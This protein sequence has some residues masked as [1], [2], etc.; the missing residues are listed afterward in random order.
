MKGKIFLT[1]FAL[2]FFGVGVWML[3]A[4]GSAVYDVTRMNDWV[5]VDARLLS[6]GYTRHSGDDSDTYEAYAEY[7]YTV[8]GRSYV[9]NRVSVSSGADNIGDYQQ[10][11]GSELSRAHSNGER[12]LVWVNPD[13]PAEAVI[14]RG[15][16]WGLAGFKSIFLIV[17]GGFGGA[18]LFYVWRMP[19]EKDKDDPRYAE[20]PWLLDDAWQTATIRSSSKASMIGMWL[21]AAVWNLVSAP[22]PF[23][24]YE[25][26]LEKQNT[27]ALVGLLFPMVGIGLLAWAIRRTL[28]WRR[29]GPTPV[30]LDPFPGSIGGHVGGTIELNEPFD[31]SVEFQLTLTNLKSYVSGSGKNRS[32]NERAEWQDMIVAH[33]E[34]SGSGTRL[35]FRFDV[36]A[37]LR[38]ADS[39]REEDTYYLWRLDLTSELDGTDLNRSF[40]IP[41]YATATQSRQLS[42]LAVDR[43]REK[44]TARDDKAVRNHIRFVTGM[45]GRSMRYPMLRNFWSHLAGFVVGGAFAAIGAYLVIEEG[46]RLFGAV[47]GGIG[48]LVALGTVYGMFNS[49]EVAR[50]AG[51]FTTV[52]RWLGIPVRRRQMGKHEF[53]HFEKDSRFQQQGGGKHVMHYNV[54]A[55]DRSGRRIV[56]GEGFRGDSQAEAAMRLIGQELGLSPA[57]NR[58]GPE[59]PAAPVPQPR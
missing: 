59:L 41:V 8:A 9:A 39:L 32:R 27:I 48:G 17:F 31:A 7:A 38:E 30:T 10:D 46:Q 6:G 50:D 37:G 52:R 49:L 18:L 47:F 28:E 11:I 57:R 4:I 55:V 34:S 53:H 40:D 14:D 1:L 2:P 20:S 21:F 24:L 56:V 22:L 23:V 12:I 13:N 44:Q 29:F 43:G 35:T 15:M 45:G 19:P 51:G 42:Q 25:E 3:W 54:Y 5:Q 16:R 58:P 26:V 36:P 33:A